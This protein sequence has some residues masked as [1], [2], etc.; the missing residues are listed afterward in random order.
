ME[1]SAMKSASGWCD[2]TTRSLIAPDSVMEAR[3]STSFASDATAVRT[4]AA[5]LRSHQF[6]HSNAAKE[7]AVML[8]SVIRAATL[9]LPVLERCFQ[10][11][12]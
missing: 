11:D 6:L 2:A 9:T 7:F 5:R 10:T 3:S 1:I 12:R 4:H 8:P